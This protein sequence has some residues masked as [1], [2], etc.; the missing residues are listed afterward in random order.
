MHSGDLRLS[1]LHTH[2]LECAL[3]LSERVFLP[4]INPV[5][6]HQCNRVLGKIGY[7]KKKESLSNLANKY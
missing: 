6:Q 2:F 7:K 3:K 1:P 4:L 5:S